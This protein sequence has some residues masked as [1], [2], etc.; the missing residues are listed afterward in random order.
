MQRPVKD[1][2]LDELGAVARLDA[3]VNALADV[4]DAPEDAWMRP[5]GGR[6]RE[7]L[8]QEFLSVVP[9]RPPTIRAENRV[10]V[11]ILSGVLAAAAAFVMFWR[12]SAEP[13]HAPAGSLGYQ[14]SIEG[15]VVAQRGEPADG[16]PTFRSGER[17]RL[18]LTPST[19]VHDPLKLRVIATHGARRVEPSWRWHVDP[20]EG[21]IEIEGPA[22]DLLNAAA[23]TWTLTV[24][25]RDAASPHEVRDR[26]SASVQALP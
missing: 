15:Q 8:L 4:Q 5:S 24:E 16:I 20:R 10:A 23:G 22:D 3:R 6:Q 9:I 25:L 17:V 21:A 1:N 12:P 18:L 14:L 26:V 2:L 7:I 11:L 13:V 19:P